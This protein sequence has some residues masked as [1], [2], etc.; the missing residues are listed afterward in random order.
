M[1]WMSLHGARRTCRV[2]LGWLRRLAHGLRTRLSAQARYQRLVARAERLD[3]ERAWRG[4]ADCYARAAALRPDIYAARQAEA[5]C[6]ALAGDLL[7]ALR[8]HRRVLERAPKSAHDLYRVGELLGQLGRYDEALPYLQ[9]ACRL[10]PDL[11]ERREVLGRMHWIMHQYD[12]AERIWA[13]WSAA[14]REAAR[15]ADLDAEAY[16][17]LNTVWTGWLGNNAH[18]DA[19]VKLGLLG[20]RPQVPLKLLA[21]EGRTANPTYARLWAPYVELVT[22]PAEVEKLEA[23]G[24]LLGESLYTMEVK[25]IS[26]YFPNAIALAQAEWER[27]RRDPLLRLPED[28]MARGRAALERLGVPLDAWFVAL[29]VREQGFWREEGDPVNAPRVAV[30][31]SYL[32]AIRAVVSAGG[33]VVRLGDPTMRPLPFME[34]VVDYALSAAK[35]DW[36][37]VFLSACCRFLVGT[38]SALYQASMSF[39]VPAVATNWMPLSSFPM[40]R[41]DIVLPKLLRSREGRLLSFREMLALPRDVWSG[42]MY[43]RLGLEIIDNTPEE[44]VEAADEMLKRLAGAWTGIEGHPR[45]SDKFRDVAAANRVEVNGSLGER[46]LRRHADLLEG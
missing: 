41:R 28:L 43:E 12:S 21:P 22:D 1:S 34:G 2:A 13:A 32:P 9:R 42:Y 35:S 37:D 6:K 3:R 29:H 20:W 39:G 7:G 30:I 31:E 27:Q 23:L 14:Q 5:R 36:M 19:Y 26:T 10:R 40:Q 4:A 25:G 8:A 38:N 33:W 11:L 18:L 16:R 15:A 46:F 24:G 44:I 17:I 45:R